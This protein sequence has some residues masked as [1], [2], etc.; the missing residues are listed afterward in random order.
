MRGKHLTP[1]IVDEHTHIAA[2]RGINEGTQAS[3]A[4]TI[5]SSEREDVNIYRQRPGGVTTARSC[6][7]AAQS[8][9]KAPSSNSGGAPHRKKCLRRPHRSSNLRLART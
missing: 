4:E 9:A 5:Q 3:S 6:G 8:V 7:S 2:T 1:G